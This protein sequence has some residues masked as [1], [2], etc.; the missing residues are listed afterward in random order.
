[1][2]AVDLHANR[3]AAKHIYLVNYVGPEQSCWFNK[4][5][6]LVSGYCLEA[7][8]QV[9]KQKW[10]S[11]YL[12]YNLPSELCCPQKAAEVAR[13]ARCLQVMLPLLVSH[14]A[15]A[16]LN[17]HHPRSRVLPPACVR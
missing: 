1:M 13:P 8:Q 5:Q 9:G 3:F 10:F 17:N 11:I 2:A 15:N 7:H 14:I 16:E 4:P 6:A 12:F